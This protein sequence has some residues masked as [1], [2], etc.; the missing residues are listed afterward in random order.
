MQMFLTKAARFF[1]TLLPPFGL[2]EDR[3][4]P[5]SVEVNVRSCSGSVREGGVIVMRSVFVRRLRGN[6]VGIVSWRYI[7]SLK[8]FMWVNFGSSHS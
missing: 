1:G 4:P 7:L 2:D 8:W 5:K 6:C 3:A